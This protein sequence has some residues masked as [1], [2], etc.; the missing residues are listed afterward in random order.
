[1]IQLC[2]VLYSDRTQSYY[3]MKDLHELLDEHPDR[4]GEMVELD[5]RNRQAFKELHHFQLTG[6][7]LWE[8]PILQKKKLERILRKIKENDPAQFMNIYVNNDKGITRYKS[9]LNTKKNR[10]ELEAAKWQWHIDRFTEENELI[11][12]MLNE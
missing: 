8:H 2:I 7:F 12:K 10:T 11:E 9:F 6:D 4:A 1:M 5:I 3:K